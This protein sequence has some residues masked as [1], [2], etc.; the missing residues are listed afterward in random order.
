MLRL[1]TCD[2][3]A[4]FE[5]LGGVP[6]VDTLNVA[7]VAQVDGCR[8]TAPSDIG[9]EFAGSAGRDDGAAWRRCF[10]GD[11]R[12]LADR[13]SVGCTEPHTAEWISSPDPA[14]ATAESCQAAATDYLAGPVTG[15]PELQVN[16]LR[17]VE[18]GVGK[19][20]C[21]IVVRTGA[22]L[23][24]TLRAIGNAQLPRVR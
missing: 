19:P 7:V 22:P 8:L 16:P 14:D 12:V 4:A 1:G 13:H 24:G 5:Y 10:D 2:V 3:D 6:G 11:V 15:R 9:G 20:R 17:G 23:D 18:P 21:E